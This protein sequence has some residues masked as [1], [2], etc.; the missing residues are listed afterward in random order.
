VNIFSPQPVPRIKKAAVIP[1]M[2]IVVGSTMRFRAACLL[3]LLGA[4]SQLRTI[5]AQ[6]ND[7]PTQTTQS[8]SAPDLTL[9]GDVHGTEN[10]TYI[11]VPFQ[12]PANT[13]R[14]T[15]HFSYTGKEQHTALDMGLLDPAELRCW[16]G[17]NKSTLTVSLSDATPSCLPG[18]LPSGTWNILIG[19]PNIRPGVIS[20]YTV[21]VFFA[22]AGL[23]SEDPS[24]LREPLRAGPAWYRGDLHMH[25]GHSDGQ[26]PSQ[27][28]QMVPCPVFFTVDAA[29]RRGLDFIAITDHNAT[30]HYD[31]MRELQPYFDKVLLIPGREITTF[32]G[33]FNI[34]GT[35]QFLD[36]RLGSQAVP[37]VNDLWRKGRELGALVS[38]NH[39]RAPTGEICMGC[40]FTPAFPADMGLVDAIEAVNGGS[41]DP[42]YS[43]IPFWEHQLDLGNRLTA[44]GGSDSHRPMTP[45]DKPGSV[46]R[47]STVVYAEE[48][49][50]PAILAAIRAGHVFIDLAGSPDR[51]LNIIATCGPQTAR[52]GDH[53]DAPAGSQVTFDVEVD[54]VTEGSVI[55]LQ[56]GKPLQTLTVP[57]QARSAMHV[58][59]ASDGQRHWFHANVVGSDQ[60]LLLLG[61]PVYL[62]WKSHP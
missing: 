47:P 11:E 27:S 33:H 53:L 26:C 19:V 46:G 43:G 22:R 38:I 39:P 18:V 32:Q 21:Q 25:T 2:Q 14:V 9:K 50:T 54:G 45:L 1:K 13:Q 23:V 59:W 12:V 31:A 24:I 16:S 52:M 37:T 6:Q 62:N 41:D 28:G 44:I 35:T 51:I 60:K 8:A 40:G 4:I 58:S 55:L 30:S 17:G 5:S 15:I 57:S 56:D 61:N 36:F 48:L 20:H 10:N 34:F 29:A 42:V 3:L 49:S 7:R